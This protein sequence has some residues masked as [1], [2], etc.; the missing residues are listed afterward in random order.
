MQIASGGGQGAFNLFSFGA[1]EDTYFGL[2]FNRDVIRG[3]RGDGIEL[4]MAGNPLNE[5]LVDGE[6]NDHFV[7]F[8]DVQVRDN[9][10]RGYD[11]LNRA[12][13][14]SVVQILGSEL[15]ADNSFV[16]G[17]GGEGVYVVN[18]ASEN[19]FQNGPTPTPSGLAPFTGDFGTP[20]PL[21]D[22]TH[23]LDATGDLD[24]QPTLNF[25]FENTVVVGNG[26]N[27][28]FD[29]N[30]VV[31]RVGSSGSVP[32]GPVDPFFDGSDLSDGGF[33]SANVYDLAERGVSGNAYLDEIVRTRSG[34]VA[35]IQN[36][37]VTGN[38][39]SDFLFESFV[40][41]PD[42]VDSAFDEDPFDVDAYQQDPKARLDLVFNA[43]TFADSDG[44]SLDGA[45][46]AGAYYDNGDEF[47][48]RPF[49]EGGEVNDPPG[50]FN[51][52]TPDDRRRNAQRLDIPALSAANPTL[53]PAV[54]VGESTFRVNLDGTNAAI[55]PGS[56]GPTVLTNEVLFGDI[57][58]PL[59]EGFPV[60][61]NDFFEW[62]LED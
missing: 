50:P 13:A 24:V 46:T 36:N 29:A 53:F 15:S 35:V 4:A 59:G 7:S 41:T 54:G 18:T 21:T 32:G 42:P 30:G 37:R 10:G 61:F 31:V 49:A 25:L 12:G 27:S 6:A 38:L 1:T 11:V 44:G 3:N 33:A 8:A 57:S 20:G 47:K 22:P 16:S 52:D 14:R 60:G 28:G 45:V 23:G 48:S 9:D 2:N 40:S 26:S 5:G 43:N 51:N 56:G 19:Q 17:N 55:F 58:V 62:N 34:V 39:G